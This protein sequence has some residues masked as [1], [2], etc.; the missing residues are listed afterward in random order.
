[1]SMTQ[2]HDVP[3]TGLIPTGRTTTATSAEVIEYRNDAHLLAKHNPHAVCCRDSPVH[4]CEGWQL[5]GAEPWPRAETDLVPRETLLSPRPLFNVIAHGGAMMGR[6][7]M[8]RIRGDHLQ[9]CQW[10]Y[11]VPTG[12]VAL[13]PPFILFASPY[14]SLR[15]RQWRNGPVRQTIGLERVW[16][17]ELICCST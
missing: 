16:L 2:T 1:M 9:L 15:A 8:R 5:V 6:I 11:V 14:A 12:C 4:L 13:I 17:K 10:R 3:S 7:P